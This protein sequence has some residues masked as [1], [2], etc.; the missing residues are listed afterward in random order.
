MFFFQKDISTADNLE[1]VAST[2]AASP[3]RFSS[4]FGILNHC[5]TKIGARTLRSAILQPPCTVPDVE[6]RLDCVQ[7]MLEVPQM[8]AAVQVY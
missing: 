4:L 6:S 3:R 2:C 1:L 7:E 5:Y 8:L